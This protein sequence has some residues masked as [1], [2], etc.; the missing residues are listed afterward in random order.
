VRS[1]TT[2]EAEGEALD[3]A[4][5]E[6]L[7]GSGQ[8]TSLSTSFPAEAHAAVWMLRPSFADR[9]AFLGQLAV[10]GALVGQEVATPEGPVV[11]VVREDGGNPIRDRWAMEQFDAAWTLA[12]AASW[13]EALRGAD[14][15]FVLTRGLLVD[16]VALL[17]LAMERVGRKTGA[18][19]LLEMAAGSRGEGFG[20]QVREKRDELACQCLE[21]VMPTR[22]GLRSRPEIYAAR[23][24]ALGRSFTREKAA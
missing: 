13:P 3:R 24:R 21:V 23:H 20:R 10:G 9:M 2:S 16:R 8:G 19:G 17:S 15:A 12:Q 4:A 14:L 11:A 7:Q 22:T 1:Y 5:W 6:A 18:D